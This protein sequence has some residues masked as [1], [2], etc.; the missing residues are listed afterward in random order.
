MEV[1]RSVRRWREKR[2]GEAGSRH[3]PIAAMAG[4][5]VKPDKRG[6]RKEQAKPVKPDNSGFGKEQR[7]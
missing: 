6:F 1:Y 7:G 4:K 2:K 3:A 5:T